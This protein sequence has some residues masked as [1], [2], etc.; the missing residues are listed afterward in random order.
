ML[1]GGFPRL[2]VQRHRAKQAG[3]PEPALPW[4]GVAL[5]G[6]L[7]VAAFA[8]VVGAVWLIAR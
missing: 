2:L 7:F 5:A 1:D 8:V 3:H 4:L 6:G